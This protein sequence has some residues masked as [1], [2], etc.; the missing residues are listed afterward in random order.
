MTQNTRSFYTRLLV[1]LFLI[2]SVASVLITSVVPAAKANGS[3]IVDPAHPQW[4]KHDGGNS[5][6]L[7]GPGDPEDFLF[8]GSLNPNG[9]RAGDQMALIN[10]LAANGGNS[11]YFEM[12]RSHGGD[13]NA[14]HNP[15]VNNDPA[16][17][18][19]AAVLD[20]W[21]TWFTA[22]DQAG[23]LIYAFFFDDSANVWGSGDSVPT[24][25]RDFLEAIVA[26]FKHHQHLMWVV[27]EEYQ[28]AFSAT[29]IANMAAI[30]RAADDNHHPIG[31]HKLS[32]LSFSEFADNPNLDQFSI[33][34]NVGNAQELHSGMVDAFADA[35]GRYNLNMSETV[36]HGTGASARLK[37]WAVA[38]G[39]AYVMVFQWDIAG[40]ATS[41]LQD[42][43]RLVQFMETTNF[44]QMSPRDDLAFGGTEYVLA[45][46]SSSSYILYGFSTY[47][48]IGVFNGGLSGG[49]TYDL[50]WLDIPSGTV[51]IRQGL[52]ATFPGRM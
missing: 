40:T 14:T 45:D 15:F 6:F 28:E 37:N 1:S 38:M 32:G 10:K 30:I 20:Q 36:G 24:A 46:P 16:Q 31:V 52:L 19:N 5:F 49:E 21:E 12:I 2:F 8:R 17:G 4:F 7:C 3:L 9:T 29:R 47:R 35:A 34:Y 33:Q 51:V 43:G 23:I 44:S 26:R 27:A 50:H 25:E 41:D 22:M 18:L 42:C 11:I 48:E 39:G 13:G